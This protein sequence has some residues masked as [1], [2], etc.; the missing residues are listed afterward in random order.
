MVVCPYHEII[1][2]ILFCCKDSNITEDEIIG[3]QIIGKCY[4]FKFQR[5]SICKAFK[6]IIVKDDVTIELHDNTYYLFKK[7]TLV[8]ACSNINEIHVILNDE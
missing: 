2:S 3:L 6:P 8:D 1:D 7:N 4:G 5:S